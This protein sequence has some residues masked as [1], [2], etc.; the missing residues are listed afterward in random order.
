ML[1]EQFDL[2]LHQPKTKEDP[3]SHR[4]IEKRRRD[5]M[6][7]CLAD[8]SRLIP[9]EYMKKGRGRVEKTEIVEMAIKHM[10]HLQSHVSLSGCFQP[11]DKK[12]QES[13]NL[14]KPPPPPESMEKSMLITEQY[15]MG[16][17]E[18]LTETMQY[19]VEGHGYSP[20]HGLCLSLINHLQEHCAQVIKCKQVVRDVVKDKFMLEVNRFNATMLMKTEEKCDALFEENNQLSDM[21]SKSS[22]SQ[23]SSNTFNDQI[24][25][26]RYIN[27]N[28][29][30]IYTDLHSSN[31]SMYKFKTDIK[32]RFSAENSGY[33]LDEFYT[34]DR[35]RSRTES[36]IGNEDNQKVPIFA[37]HAN[38][39]YYIPLT[40]NRQIISPILDSVITEN[41][42]SVIVHP[43]SISVNFQSNI[44]L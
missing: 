7:S 40:I 27:H 33:S 21:T 19:L 38:G 6:N 41:P 2:N 4:I 25:P 16:F 44:P 23:S 8:L 39:S 37:L 34:Q 17:F 12:Q 24:L 35:K 11:C 43:I 31:G 9:A 1:E 22:K 5:R 13:D 30:M 42:S 29:N 36:A 18:C 28:N 15:K 20:R 26:D 32:Q 3:M 10:K 14:E